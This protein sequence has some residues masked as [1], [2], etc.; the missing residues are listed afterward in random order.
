MVTLE[1][2][3]LDAGVM[4]IQNLPTFASL[5]FPRLAHLS[6]TSIPFARG[7]DLENFIT[8]HGTTLTRLRLDKCP[9][10]TGRFD[11]SGHPKDSLR[12]QSVIWT[13]FAEVLEVLSEIIVDRTEDLARY[14]WS[15]GLIIMADEE[16]NIPERWREDDLALKKL[17]A[18]AH[19]RRKFV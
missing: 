6:L 19:S 4:R 16:V 7:N 10:I 14:I 13:H 2:L 8:R 3:T 12:C 9:V 1:S 11:A 17:R 18:L 5:F 15:D